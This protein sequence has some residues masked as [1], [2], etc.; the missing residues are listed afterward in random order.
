MP[1]VYLPGPAPAVTVANRINGHTQGCHRNFVPKKFWEQTRN[2]FRYSAEK[3]A[4]SVEF[5]VHRKSQFR[6]SE[7]NGMKRN[8]AEIMKFYETANKSHRFSSV[9]CS[10]KQFGMDFQVLSL[11]KMVR[12]GIPRFFSSEN[13]WERNFEVFSSENG[14]E[15]NS[16][17]LSL[18]MVWNGMVFLFQEIVQNG[19]SRFFSSVKQTE[20][21]KN[22]RLFRLVSYSTE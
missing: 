5:R 12:N 15:R 20:F 21:R 10:Q 13:G 6:S 11:T 1:C 22:S 8:S 16:K 2:G 17:V 3:S 7:L 19:I 9:F 14:L 18:K 4:H